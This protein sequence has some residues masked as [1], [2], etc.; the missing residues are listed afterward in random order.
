MNKIVENRK[1]CPFLSPTEKDTEGDFC[2]K[3]KCI[4]Y[5]ENGNKC[6]INEQKE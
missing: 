5:S 1:K 2:L 3:A 4:W 6:N